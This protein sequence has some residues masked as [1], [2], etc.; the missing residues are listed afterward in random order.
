[1]FTALA[2]DRKLWLRGKAVCHSQQEQGPDRHPGA[3]CPRLH[4]GAL[5]TQRGRGLYR[6]MDLI[7]QHSFLKKSASCSRPRGC[8]CLFPGLGHCQG[9][10]S[11]SQYSSRAASCPLPWPGD[12]GLCAPSLAIPQQETLPS[13]PRSATWVL[14]CPGFLGFVCFCV[15]VSPH[16]RIFLR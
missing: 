10:G 4:P 11:E 14:F 3:R 1:M 2:G 15:F 12:L 13:R 9:P 5:G 6:D 8:F 7:I 16:P